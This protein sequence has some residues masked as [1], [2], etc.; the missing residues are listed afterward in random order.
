MKKTDKGKSVRAVP[1]GFL[2][3]TPYLVVDHASDLIEFLKEAFD[4]KE[5]FMHKTEDGKVMHATVNI[6]NSP[7]MISDTMDGMKPQTGMFYLYLENVD[8][9]F[10]KALKAKATTLRDIRD[11]FYGD[12]A[13]SVK[14]D[15]GNVWWIA[16]H[17][18]DVEPDELERRAKE[19]EVQQED[20]AHR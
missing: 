16:T 7:V 1:E 20:H 9:V 4:G 2:T 13:G 19:K 17:I 8:E 15:W 6:G 18:E 14:D 11:E 10:Q 3:I 12:R 5:T